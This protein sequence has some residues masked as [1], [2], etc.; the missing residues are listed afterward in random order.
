[1]AYLDD[2]TAVG[3]VLLC[4]AGICF[5]GTVGARA[6]ALIGNA[7]GVFFL[8]EVHVCVAT[9]GRAFIQID[10]MR[11]FRYFVVD[12]LYWLAQLCIR[13]RRFFVT[14]RWRYEQVC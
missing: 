3:P 13:C 12:C 10:V 14:E 7:S 6:S 5:H 8:D 9:A 1:M 2:I 4:G 11:R